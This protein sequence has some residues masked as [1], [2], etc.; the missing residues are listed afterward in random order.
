M[1]KK[2]ELYV[3]A[4]LNEESKEGW[5]WIPCI[6]G[7]ESNFI[8]IRNLETKKHII[9][10]K[11]LLD[12]N[13]INRYNNR[14]TTRNITIDKC[15]IINEYYRSELGNISPGKKIN[16]EITDVKCPIW[17]YI[18][19]P[20]KHPNPYVRASIILGI[21]SLTLGALSI[22]LSILTIFGLL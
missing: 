15:I 14:K 19:A 6:K 21:I 11:R 22:L 17:K 3:Y 9:C 8:K 1:K 5:V 20:L 4:S 12:E 2:A 7:I 13:Y 10:E 16:F 18:Y